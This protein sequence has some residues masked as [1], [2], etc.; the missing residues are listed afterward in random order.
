MWILG[1]LLSSNPTILYTIDNDDLKRKNTTRNNKTNSQKRKLSL[2][3]KFERL[4][5]GEY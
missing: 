5:K 2:W 3:E 1:N 4:C